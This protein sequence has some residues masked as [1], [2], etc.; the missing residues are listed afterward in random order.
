MREPSGDQR[1]MLMSPSSLV[2]RRGC[3]PSTLAT[4]S[5]PDQKHWSEPHSFPLW[6]AIEA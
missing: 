1:G 4:Y 3:V 5:S 6:S 2:S